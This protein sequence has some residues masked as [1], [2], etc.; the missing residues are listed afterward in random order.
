MIDARIRGHS[1]YQ[2]QTVRMIVKNQN[3]LNVLASGRFCLLPDDEDPF[4]EDARLFAW[5]RISGQPSLRISEGPDEGCRKD[6]PSTVRAFPFH[7]SR[8][9]RPPYRRYGACVGFFRATCGV[10]L[11][12]SFE[13]DQSS[14]DDTD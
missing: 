6:Y 4:R 12:P 2:A 8:Y 13:I 1:K 5:R 9:D 10:I 11:T 7:G 3:L 14:P